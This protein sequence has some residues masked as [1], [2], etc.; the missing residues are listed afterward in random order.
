[1][2]LAVE[3]GGFTGRWYAGEPQEGQPA[4]ITNL[5]SESFRILI[6]Y[7]FGEL[8]IQYTSA[9]E[10]IVHEKL[11]ILWL[12]LGRERLTRALFNK[13][14]LIR[15]DRIS[16]LRHVLEETLRQ[17]NFETGPS[18]IMTSIYGHRWV[19]HPEHQRTYRYYAMLLESL[20][21]SSDLALVAHSYRLTP[22]ALSTLSS[23][24]AEDRRHRNE[25]RQQKI[26]GALT[27]AL[28]IVGAVQAYFGWAHP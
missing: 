15:R 26:L 20:V 18:G 9:I 25:I 23:Y 1:M 14:D 4:S 16:V 11:G 12:W 8:E 17:Q 19:H 27:A 3:N 13:K 24:E 21:G 2:V 10:F 5:S 7:Y 22:K 28:V 6:T